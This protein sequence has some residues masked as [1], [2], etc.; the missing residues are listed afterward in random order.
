MSSAARAADA[1][2]QQVIAV[3]PV[4]WP[5]ANY[6]AAMQYIAWITSVEGQ[7][8]I[9]DY[10]VGGQQLFAPDEAP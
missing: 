10:K 4:K 6:L 1:N 8:I 3:N 5:K 9:R 2:A 7:R